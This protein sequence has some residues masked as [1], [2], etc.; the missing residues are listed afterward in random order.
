MKLLLVDDEPGI[1]EG[2]ALL[3]QRRG[4]EVVTAA[5][6]ARAG[7]LL[8][9]HDGGAGFDLVLTDW[10]LPDGVAA[11]FLRGIGC[12]AIAMSGHP[13]EVA[14]RADVRA[15]LTKPVAIGDLLASLAARESELAGASASAPLP[16]DVAA[17]VARARALL[18]RDP[19][20]DDDGTFVTLRAPLGGDHAIPALLELG[21][22]LR[23]LT[24]GG[25]DTVEIRWC[26]DGRPD[27]SLPVCRPEDAWP[28]GP[29]FAVDFA[30]GSPIT[31]FAR[32]LDRAA[33]L[34]AAGRTVHFLNVPD[35]LLSW[36]SDQGRDADLPMRAAVGPRLPAVLADLWSPA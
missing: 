8:A 23:V 28:A 6:C 29:E 34:R 10:R 14:A 2:L 19:A 22:D 17:L 30:A 9:L 3:L 13:E 20:I 11:G 31:A 36:T 35:P 5:D 12:P 4:H 25:V 21:G 18:G 32:C 26:R 15:V 16:K 33:A 7:E 24:P 27:P 1:R